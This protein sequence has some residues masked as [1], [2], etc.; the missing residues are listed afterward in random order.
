MEL[1]VGFDDVEVCFAEQYPGVAVALRVHGAGDVQAALEFLQ[2]GVE[3]ALGGV[4][5]GNGVFAQ[6]GGGPRLDA[7][8]F[9]DLLAEQ[10][11]LADRLECLWVMRGAQVF[12]LHEDGVAV[13]QL[14]VEYLVGKGFRDARFPIPDGNDSRAPSAA[15]GLIGREVGVVPERR[16]RRPLAAKHRD[17]LML[18]HKLGRFFEGFHVFRLLW[19]L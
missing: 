1:G 15:L 2:G 14:A 18:E 13:G 3:A 5:F 10:G 11:K 19:Q 12:A 16:M 4:E 7:H 6:R 8:A 9:V 17:H